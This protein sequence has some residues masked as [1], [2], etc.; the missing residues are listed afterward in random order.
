MA[1]LK[2]HYHFVQALCIVTT[3]CVLFMFLFLQRVTLVQ[4]II[5][6]EQQKEYTFRGNV[7]KYI[8]KLERNQVNVK[9]SKKSKSRATSTE[10]P[11]HEEGTDR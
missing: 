2:K 3:V 8:E 7:N 6:T 10:S 5:I 4:E 1:Q 9:E 11:L